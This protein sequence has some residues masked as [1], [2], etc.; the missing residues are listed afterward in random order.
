MNAFQW[1]WFVVA[2]TVAAAAGATSPDALNGFDLTTLTVSRQDVIP[3]GPPRDGIPALT[4][5]KFVA[6]TKA[7][8]LHDDARVLGIA[9]NGIAKAYP[10]DILSWHEIVNDRFGD[11]PVLVSYCPLCFT[12]IAFKAE[13][14]GTRRLFGVSGL[15][16][17][18]DVLLY[19]RATQSL[20][21]QLLGQ[22][23]SGPAAGTELEMI[24]VENTSWPVWRQAHPDT[25]V[26]S[27]DTGYTRSYDRNP[28]QWY[29]MSP[30]VSFPVAAQSSDYHPKMYVLGVIIGNDA[31]VY[32]FAELDAEAQHAADRR[33]V[34]IR[35]T[36]G[37]RPIVVHYDYDAISAYVTD[38]KDQPVPSTMA[39][40]FAWYAFHPHSRIYHSASP[41]GQPR[42]H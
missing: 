3:G 5:P 16:Y 42:H 37:G 9:R 15:L 17:N 2:L 24:A 38:T 7:D 10:L 22:A 14:G 35:D 18:S 19:D 39:Y 41:G 12:G 30:Q 20:W 6:A 32:P 27:R 26:L 1:L 31:R 36:V 34:R 40:W 28:Y 33:H 8:W 13:A 25:L 21:S 4:D 23:V 11:E 29:D